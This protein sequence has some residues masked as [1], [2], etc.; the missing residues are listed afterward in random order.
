MRPALIALVWWL[1][2]S[3]ALAQTPPGDDDEKPGDRGGAPAP[4]SVPPPEPLDSDT[5]PQPGV[6]PSP[7][8]AAT[9]GKPPA[10][11]GEHSAGDAPIRLEG[12]GD[13]GHAEGAYSG[14]SLGGQGLPPKAPKLPMKGPQRMTW[15]GFQV[16][17][18][19]PTVFLQTTGTPD[20]TVSDQAGNLV[21][22]LR[23]TT[24]KLRNNQRPLRVGEFGTGVTE[25]T[26]KPKGRD[27]VVTIKRKEGGAHRE[28]VEASAGGYQLLLVELPEK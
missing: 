12:R 6:R 21:V 15:P 22:T 1:G 8:P 14:V 25:I 18:G 28:R 24:I 17:D 2:G 20:Y 3:L 10:A 4:R 7:A 27:V 16:R 13:G 23:G 19:V 9:R 11:P 5:P 26:A